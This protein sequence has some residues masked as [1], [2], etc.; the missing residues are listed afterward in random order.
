VQIRSAEEYYVGAAPSNQF[1]F[2][3]A[4]LNERAIREGIKRIAA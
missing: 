4:S 1:M 3:F 2:G